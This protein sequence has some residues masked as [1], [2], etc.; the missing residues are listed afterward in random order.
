M[1][2]VLIVDDDA[3][4]AYAAARYLDAHGIKTFV[5]FS[6]M[7]ALQTFAR[8]PVQVVVS[9]L[10]LGKGEPHG[11]ALVR[12]IRHSNPGFPVILMT[13]YPEALDGEALPGRV[14]RKP[15]ELLDLFDEINACV[16]Q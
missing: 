3:V 14:F 7:A 1:V 12:M 11:L 9:D 6:S 15:V 16:R 8:E 13:A 5:E 2:C 4:F 10:M